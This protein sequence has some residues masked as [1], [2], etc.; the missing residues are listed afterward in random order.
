M[1]STEGDY[2]FIDSKRSRI[3]AFSGRASMFSQDQ[4]DLAA[5]QGKFA[6]QK[7]GTS[8]EWQEFE[9]ARYLTLPNTVGTPEFELYTGPK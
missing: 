9:I 8:W 5:V 3:V 4:D 6:S 7:V 1:T 2:N